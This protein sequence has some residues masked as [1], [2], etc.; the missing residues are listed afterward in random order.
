MRLNSNKKRPRE[1]AGPFPIL[2]ALKLLSVFRRR[3]LAGGL[4]DHLHRQTHL[5]T[6][7]EAKQFDPDFLTFFQNIARVVQ[8]AVL[9]LRNMHK[10]A[11]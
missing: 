2:I 5:A 4:I 10:A 11:A 3:F 1:T 8:A 7:V 9:G 6:I